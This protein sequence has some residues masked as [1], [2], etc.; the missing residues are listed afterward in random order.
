MHA[1]CLEVLGDYLKPSA[2]VLDVGS[3]TG[4]LTALF[5]EFVKSG[6]G[7]GIVVGIDHIPELVAMSR[8][9]FKKDGR[10]EMLD[11]GEVL[12]VAGDGRMGY[13][14]RAPY[15]AIHVGAAAP[16]IPEVGGV[17]TS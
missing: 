9:N 7:G 6:P 10:A 1:H 15:D 3:G 8:E 11:A 12:L 13:P 14:A 4:Y 16:S 17:T 5:A 2:R